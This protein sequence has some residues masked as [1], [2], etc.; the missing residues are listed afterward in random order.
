MDTVGQY[1]RQG[2]IEYEETGETTEDLA[3]AGGWGGGRDRSG[4]GLRM[5]RSEGAF[6][7]EVRRT[8]GLWDNAHV[9]EPPFRRLR[10]RVESRSGAE[11]RRWMVENPWAPVKHTTVDVAYRWNPDEAAFEFF[12]PDGLHWVA[13][14]GPCDEIISVPD[15]RGWEVA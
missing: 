1:G 3:E 14:A 6:V 15:V 12:P 11:L 7:T 9:F 10:E 5:N 4:D 8:D 13:Y 2:M